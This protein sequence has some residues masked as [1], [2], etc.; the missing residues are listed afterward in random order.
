MCED[1]GIAFPGGSRGGA[2]DG[3]SEV[4]SGKRIEEWGALAARTPV[5]QFA[6]G[7]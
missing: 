6:G 2:A 7:R 3:F 4:E 5:G 1:F